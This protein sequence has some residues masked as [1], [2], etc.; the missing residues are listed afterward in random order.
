MQTIKQTQQTWIVKIFIL[1]YNLSGQISFLYSFVPVLSRSTAVKYCFLAFVSN[2]KRAWHANIINWQRSWH[3]GVFSY[4]QNSLSGDFCRFQLVE[5]DCHSNLIEH[6][7]VE[8]YSSAI[9]MFLIIWLA[10]FGNFIRLW[11]KCIQLSRVLSNHNDVQSDVMIQS[12]WLSLNW[13]HIIWVWWS[14]CTDGSLMISVVWTDSQTQIV[15]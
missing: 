14:H 8:P 5:C 4:T 6:K 9:W 7:Y 12:H 10:Y 3:N 1:N 11:P 15:D 13:K 2:P